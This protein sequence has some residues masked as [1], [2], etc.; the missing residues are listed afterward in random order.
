MFSTISDLETEIRT[1]S[2][3]MNAMDLDED[4]IAAT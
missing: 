1:I 2:E 3:D 4:A